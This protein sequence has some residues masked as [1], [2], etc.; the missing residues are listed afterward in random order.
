VVG[1]SNGPR[2]VVRVRAVVTTVTVAVV[3][4]VPFG[5]TEVGETAQ[6]ESAG[7]PAQVSAMVWLNPLTGATE[8]FNTAVVPAVRVADAGVELREKSGITPAPVRM[9]VC[10]LPGPLSATESVA[11][12]VPAAE[13]V[14]TTLIEQLAP[15]DP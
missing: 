9:A 15:V 5:V 4:L 13:G 12:R 10:G 7:W 2:G 1:I 6:V 8:S 11:L 3:A 14:N